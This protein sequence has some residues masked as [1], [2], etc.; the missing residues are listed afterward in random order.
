MQKARKGGHIVLIPGARKGKR[1]Q[2]RFAC[3]GTAARGRGKYRFCNTRDLA[4][5]G[6]AR[7]TKNVDGENRYVVSKIKGVPVSHANCRI[8]ALDKPKGTGKYRYCTATQLKDLGKKRVAL[9]DGKYRIV[10]DGFRLLKGPMKSGYY[11]APLTSKPR[12]KSKSTVKALAGGSLT[13]PKGTGKYRY[14]SAAE[15]KKIGRKRHPT[16]NRI[17]KVNTAAQKKKAKQKEG[18]R[19]ARATCSGLT[20]PVAPYNEYRWCSQKELAALGMVRRVVKQ[21]KRKA[22][23]KKK[24][25]T[26]KAKKTTPKG[27]G[28]DASPYATLTLAKA[29]IR[30]KSPGTVVHYMKQYKTSAGK[31]S[32]RKA[33]LTAK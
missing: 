9:G 23:A 5:M 15:L 24:K 33:K 4:L 20:V 22:P 21:T 8:G 14:F 2:D 29:A 11:R 19:L 3:S 32:R 6:L 25:A 13:T 18:Y 27:N 28:S 1:L 30:G 26:P 12:A 31:N 16:T 7:T 17:S 10:A